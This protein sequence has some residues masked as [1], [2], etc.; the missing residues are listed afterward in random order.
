MPKVSLVAKR[1]VVVNGRKTSVS[2]EE[3]FWRALRMIAKRQGKTISELISE[4][5]STR[6][7]A[8]LSSTIRVYTLEYVLSLAQQPESSDPSEKAAR[9]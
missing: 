3:P 7:G 4:I 9:F 2:I 6:E 5:K 8:N 1:S